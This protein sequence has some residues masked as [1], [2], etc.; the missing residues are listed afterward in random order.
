MEWIGALFMVLAVA[1]LVGIYVSQPFLRHSA[2]AVKC[3]T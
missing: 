2:S 3:T 1:F